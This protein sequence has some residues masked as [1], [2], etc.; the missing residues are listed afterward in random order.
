MHG[1][2]TGNENISLD[3]CQ[4]ICLTI[5]LKALCLLALQYEQGKN[6]PKAKHCWHGEVEAVQWLGSAEHE[7]VCSFIADQP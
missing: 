1:N 6:L 5:G 7:L 4:V 3:F 2:T